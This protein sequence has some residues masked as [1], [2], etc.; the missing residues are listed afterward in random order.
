[1]YSYYNFDFDRETYLTKL[2]LLPYG[3]F[4]HLARSFADPAEVALFRVC[5]DSL[6]IHSLL[7]FA[8]R[9]SMNLTYCYRFERVLVA[10][11]WTRQQARSFQRLKTARFIPVAQNP[12]PK[13]VTAVF[14]AVSV[15]V[16]LSTHK[17]ISEATALC[18]AHPECVVFAH[19]WEGNADHC[20]CLILIDID[21]TPKTYNEWVNPAD[22]FEKVKTLA[23][24]GMLTSLQVINRQLLEWPEELRS[25]RDLKTM[26]ALGF[27]K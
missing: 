26:C 5:F 3:S 9:I 2:E 23:A 8:L 17:A 22:A 15:L 25:C 18:S 14:L 10:L 21:L 12:V 4:E 7:D 1:V 19:R 20:P 24:S 27:L 6:R 13:G 16:L 11:I